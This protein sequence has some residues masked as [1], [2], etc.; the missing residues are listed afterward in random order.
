[1]RVGGKGWACRERKVRRQAGAGPPG[2][3]ALI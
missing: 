1:M 3:C 2:C